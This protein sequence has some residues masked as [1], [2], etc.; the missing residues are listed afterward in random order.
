MFNGGAMGR[1]SV[2]WGNLQTKRNVC[3][4]LGWLV[5]LYFLCFV[6]GSV[7]VFWQKSNMN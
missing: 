1:W 6:V 3:V 4:N 7:L 5:V 2:W